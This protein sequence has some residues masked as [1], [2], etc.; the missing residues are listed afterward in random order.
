MNES[1][2]RESIAKD[3]LCDSSDFLKRFGILLEAS[4]SSH[5]GM[6]CKLIIDLIFSAE[7]SLKALIFL[8]S[9]KNEKEIYNQILTHKLQDLLV[10]L[11]IEERNK[12]VSYIDNKLIDYDIS[13]RY[14]IETHK[15]YKP[16]GF[17]SEEYY[18]TISNFEWL[19]IIY[20]NFSE[21][22]K[23]VRTKIKVPIEEITFG[24]IDVDK[25]IEEHSRIISLEKNRKRGHSS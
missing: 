18:K 2:F 1:S 9:S 24:E 20:N 7:C 14:M 12:C 11:P 4:I 8:H 16:K 21:L 23:Y 22:N 25:L 17:L 5:I 3:F 15:K 19:K 6:R 13:N 10:M